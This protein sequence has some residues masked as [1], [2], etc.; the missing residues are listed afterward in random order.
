VSLDMKQLN[1]YSIYYC[2]ILYHW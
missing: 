1:D 2:V